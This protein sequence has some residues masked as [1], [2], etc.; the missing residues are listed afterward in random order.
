MQA[1]IWMNETGLGVAGLPKGLVR[2]AETLNYGILNE[3][4]ATLKDAISLLGRYF[5]NP[6]VHRQKG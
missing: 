4:E 2:D 3:I 5:K 6:G 1:K